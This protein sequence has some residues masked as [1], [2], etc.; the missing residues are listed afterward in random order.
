[1]LWPPRTQPPLETRT[2][3]KRKLVP[4][5]R[6]QTGMPQCQATTNIHHWQANDL[7]DWASNID[8]RH[9]SMATCVS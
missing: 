8:C 3:Q 1:V 5:Q 7:D 9:Q 4:Q 6:K 2:N